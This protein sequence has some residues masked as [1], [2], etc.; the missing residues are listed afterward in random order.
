M[1]QAL[2]VVSWFPGATYQSQN[3]VWI[4]CI[5]L[6]GNIK[7]ESHYPEI[8]WSGNQWKKWRPDLPL[9]VFQLESNPIPVLDS[10]GKRN[11]INTCYILNEAENSYSLLHIFLYSYRYLGHNMIQQAQKHTTK[12]CSLIK[13]K[14]FAS[15]NFKYFIYF[16]FIPHTCIEYLL[17]TKDYDLSLK[18]T[19]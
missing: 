6:K 15:F 2:V 8:D 13:A 7:Q 14:V 19:L 16:I 17:C 9:R 3:S 12:N 11:Y 4:K 5:T 1:P 10:W 18:H